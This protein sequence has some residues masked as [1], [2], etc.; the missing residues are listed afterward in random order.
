MGA[1]P[2]PSASPDVASE[3]HQRDSSATAEPRC[4][5]RNRQTERALRSMCVRSDGSA[6]S[7]HQNA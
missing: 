4:N 7:A 2:G 6:D 1:K 3:Q 5:I